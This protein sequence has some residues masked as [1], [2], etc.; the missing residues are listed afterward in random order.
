MLK[1]KNSNAPNFGGISRQLA[2]NLEILPNAIHS[3][4]FPIDFPRA[5]DF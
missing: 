5:T 2:E 1:I 4:V 3:S